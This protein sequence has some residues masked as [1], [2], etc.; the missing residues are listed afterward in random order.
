MKR[1]FLLLDFMNGLCT[2]KYITEHDIRV[3]Q[4]I[5]S[6]ASDAARKLNVDYLTYKKWCKRMGI[7]HL[8]PLSHN[9]PKIV[10]DPNSG[11]R[12]IE[13]IIN[14]EFPTYSYHLIKPKLIRA[15][16]KEDKCD[17]CGYTEKRITDNKTPIIIT[18]RD[19]N[20][21]NHLLSNIQFMCYNCAHN[22]GVNLF[23]HRLKLN[24]Y[25]NASSAKT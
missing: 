20:R 9:R 4:S 8:V 2:S 19:G 10:I 23:G 15:G 18:F 1:S 7:P 6:C 13:K 11:P 16:I 12:P 3:A 17:I 21:T 25:K 5:A 14:G 22:Y 24:S